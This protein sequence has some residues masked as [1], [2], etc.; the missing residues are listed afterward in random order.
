MAT[1][2][3]SNIARKSPSSR[4]TGLAG[5]PNGRNSKPNWKSANTYTPRTRKSYSS[6]SKAA[7]SMANEMARESLSGGVKSLRKTK[8]KPT[9]NRQRITPTRQGLMNYKNR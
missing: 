6:L 5:S 7:G 1:G 4:G 9:S 2:A 8:R 3:I